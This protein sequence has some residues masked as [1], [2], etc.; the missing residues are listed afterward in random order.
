MKHIS[1]SGVKDNDGRFE[2][3]YT[4]GPCIGKGTLGEVRIC[5]NK[6]TS[7]KRAV[8]IIRKSAL[9]ENTAQQFIQQR[10]LLQ[11]LDHPNLLNIY[12]SF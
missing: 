10:M 9:D 11:A 7:Q 5:T 4:M 8:R 3:H 12:E 2:E 1:F 6:A